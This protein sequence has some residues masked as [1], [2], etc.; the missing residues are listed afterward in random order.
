MVKLTQNF[1]IRHSKTPRYHP[2]SIPTERCNRSIKTAI[3]ADFEKNHKECDGKLDDL[4][5]ALK[6]VSMHQQVCTSIFK[7]LKGIRTNRNIKERLIKH[8]IEEIESQD[9]S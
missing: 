6:P 4:Q 3:K 9:V 2:Q 1:G 7:F 5:F 8:T